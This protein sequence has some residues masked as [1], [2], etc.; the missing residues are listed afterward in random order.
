MLIITGDHSTP[1]SLKAHSWH[2]VPLLMKAPS[3]RGGDGGGF[4]EIACRSGQIGT[5]LGKE[6]IPLGMAHCGKLEKFGA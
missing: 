4:N 6:I 5:I 1:P 2:A 3:T